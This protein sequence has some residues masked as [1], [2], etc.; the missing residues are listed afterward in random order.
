MAKKDIVKYQFDKR[1]AE[2]QQAIAKKGGIASGESR[3]LAKTFKDAI[4]DNL[5][6][7]DLT[8]IINKVV[9]MAKKGNLKAFELIRDTRGEKPVE[10][11]NVNNE[12]ATKVLDSINKQLQGKDK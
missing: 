7:K 8:T 3:R 4:N 12:K 10:S 5:S 1:T 9:A 2:E 6:D 11:I